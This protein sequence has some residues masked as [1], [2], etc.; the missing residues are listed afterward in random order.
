MTKNPFRA[1]K[2]LLT[3]RRHLARR[4]Q[5]LLDQMISALPAATSGN[6]T[7]L[8]KVPSGR[9][10]LTCPCRSRPRARDRWGHR[11]THRRRQWSA[12][13][14]RGRHTVCY[15]FAW[16]TSDLVMNAR[17]HSAA[18]ASTEANPRDEAEVSLFDRQS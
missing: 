6:G 8:G 3:Q 10:A 2:R 18:L 7:R 5:K 13:G 9:K 1:L 4:E 11:W 15:R 12:C 17:A 14:R 16:L